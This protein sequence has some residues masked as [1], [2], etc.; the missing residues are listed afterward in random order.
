VPPVAGF[1][2]TANVAVSWKIASVA[3][4]TAK[5]GLAQWF[6]KMLP[7]SG[8]YGQTFV[9]NLVRAPTLPAALFKRAALI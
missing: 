7:E 2:I 6:A 5:S 1:S 3:G 9:R 4:G 8:D